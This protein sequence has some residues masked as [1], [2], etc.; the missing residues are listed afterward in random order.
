MGTGFTERT[1]RNKVFRHDLVSY[2]VKVRETDLCISSDTDLTEAALQSVHKHRGHLESYIRIHPDFLTSLTPLEEDHLAPDIVR[3]M[4]KVSGLTGVG[5]MASVAGAV[6]EHVGRDLLLQNHN[7]IV[8]NGGDIYLNTFRD[9]TVGIFAGDSPLSEKIALRVHPSEMPLGICTSSATVGPSLSLGRADA[10]CVKCRSAVLA[11]AAATAIGNLS[12]TKADIR[13]AIQAGSGI[14]G[15]LGILIIME[16]E[17]GVWGK[18][19]L[20]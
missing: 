9:I 19:E 5:P 18:M 7:V 6:A 1:Y 12:K 2:Q 10:V 16:A 11:D 4:L 13:K 3:D 14:S 17:L 15:V 8:E 20:V